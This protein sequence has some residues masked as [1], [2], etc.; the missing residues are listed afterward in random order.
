MFQGGIFLDIQQ[1]VKK[2]IKKYNTNNPFELCKILN[3]KM[4]KCPL[5]KNVKGF[6]QNILRISV[7][8]I[9]SDLD[10]NEQRIV[11]GHELGHAIL[12]TK[13]NV[14]FLDRNTLFVKNR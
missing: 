3:I 13:V 6:Y 7:V 8:Y 12:H 4:V 11:C 14:V 2:L 5:D 1:I 10:E 9:N